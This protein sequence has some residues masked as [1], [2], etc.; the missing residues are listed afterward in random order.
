MTLFF[1]VIDGNKWDFEGILSAYSMMSSCFS[2][3]RPSTCIR[4]LLS[5]AWCPSRT[6]RRPERV[7]WS[8]SGESAASLVRF[9]LRLPRLMVRGSLWCAAGRWRDWSSVW[10]GSPSLR[11]SLPWGNPEDTRQPCLSNWWF[12]LWCVSLSH[13]HTLQKTHVNQ[14]RRKSWVCGSSHRK[15]CTCGTASPSLGNV[16]ITLR[17]YWSPSRERKSSCAAIP[18]R[19][20]LSRLWAFSSENSDCVWGKNLIVIYFHDK[21]VAV[22]MIVYIMLLVYIY[23]EWV[24]YY[25][26]KWIH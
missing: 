13:T 7:S 20:Y 26:Y 3:L 16:R 14:E 15:W 9:L 24:G 19:H 25:I 10:P 8:C 6:W 5:W 21:N 23:H 22:C 1:E 4:K 11:R 17:A 2:S 18:V 12:L